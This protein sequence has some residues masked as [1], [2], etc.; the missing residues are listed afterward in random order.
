MVSTQSSTSL[1][2]P[3]SVNLLLGKRGSIPRNKR[4]L[5]ALA[6]EL[7]LEFENKTASKLRSDVLIQMG[8]STRAKEDASIEQRRSDQRQRRRELKESARKSNERRKQIQKQSQLIVQLQ[9]IVDKKKEILSIPGNQDNE[10]VLETI[11][12]VFFQLIVF[13]LVRTINGLR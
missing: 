2:I 9:T 12:Q 11:I 5:Q 13:W 4:A 6:K 10:F 7:N 3:E 8:K 1:N